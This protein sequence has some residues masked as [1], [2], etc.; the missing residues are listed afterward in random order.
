MP[1]RTPILGAVAAATIVAGLVGV[2]THQASTT[3]STGTQPVLVAAYR[4]TVATKSSAIALHEVVSA[5]GG[6][7]LSITGAGTFEY[8]VGGSFQ[9]TVAGIGQQS[10]IG[11]VA[12]PDAVYVRLPTV[13]Q[14]RFDGKAWLKLPIDVTGTSAVTPAQTLDSLLGVANDV[15][16]TGTTTI[17]RARVT[18]YTA[19]IDPT[20]TFSKMPASLAPLAQREATAFAAAGITDL[21]TTVYIDGQGRL[22]R[23]VSRLSLHVNGQAVAATTTVDIGHFG[24]PVHVQIPPAD[25]VYFARSIGG[26]V[27]GLSGIGN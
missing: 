9:A 17:D 15:R 1:L 10:T 3:G 22:R 20:R 24:I 25:Q 13:A 2:A 14:G 23:L 19:D 5:P 6:L 26:I 12:T 21:P 7:N 27:A 4:S 18:V 11:E 16:R 8:G